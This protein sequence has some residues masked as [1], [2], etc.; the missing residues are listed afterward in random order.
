M[1]QTATI[2]DIRQ[3]STVE[4]AM[5]T[6]VPAI[7]ALVII[8][9]AAQPIAPII[10]QVA[11]CCLGTPKRIAKAKVPM[12]AANVC[13]PSPAVSALTVTPLSSIIPWNM[14]PSSTKLVPTPS[15]IQK[16]PSIASVSRVVPAM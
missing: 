14:L 8:R 13:Q 10:P 11:Y 1:S 5:D 4:K 15:A 6:I 16:N 7:P 12:N 2:L 9:N 3:I